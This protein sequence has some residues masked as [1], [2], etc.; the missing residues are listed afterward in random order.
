M[1]DYNGYTTNYNFDGHQRLLNIKD[2]QSFLLKDFYYHYANQVA[3]TDLGVTPTNTLNYVV[4]RT[5]RTEQTGNKL[6]SNVD[7]TT[8][9]IQYSDGLS[10]NL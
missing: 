7:S 8:T 10:R 6:T 5:A 3:L 9:E 1:T 2:P 4:S